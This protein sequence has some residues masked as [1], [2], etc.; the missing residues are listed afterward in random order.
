MKLNP[1]KRKPPCPLCRSKKHGEETYHQL[2][3]QNYA[4][5]VQQGRFFLKTIDGSDIPHERQH[6]ITLEL[7]GYLDIFLAEA[8]LLGYD[9]ETRE[10][11]LT[12][13]C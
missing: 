9:A 8:T 11:L 13:M 1:F 3:V 6:E 2:R 7:A 12:P 5:L 4:L 10:R